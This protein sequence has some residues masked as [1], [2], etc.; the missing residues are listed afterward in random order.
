ML[1]RHSSFVILALA[2]ILVATFTGASILPVDA[3][4][5]SLGYG[6]NGVWPQTA[7][8]NSQRWFR[9]HLNW[10]A[11]KNTEGFAAERIDGL[12]LYGPS[13]SWYPAAPSGATYAWELYSSKGIFDAGTR[14]AGP[15]GVR[16]TFVASPTKVYYIPEP[17]VSYDAGEMAGWE[18]TITT[19][20]GDGNNYLIDDNASDFGGT[21]ITLDTGDPLDDEVC[22]D[23]EITSKPSDTR[24]YYDPIPAV[25]YYPNHTLGGFILRFSLGEARGQEFDIV[26]NSQTGFGYFIDVDEDLPTD[27][28]QTLDADS[29]AS[30]TK[31][32]YSGATFD[33]NELEGQ[34][35]VITSGTATGDER[36][37]SYNGTDGTGDYIE[38]TTNLPAGFAATDT[39]ELKDVM[40]VCDLAQVEN[41]LAANDLPVHFGV[42]RNTPEASTGDNPMRVFTVGPFSNYHDDYLVGWIPTTCPNP[43]FDNFEFWLYYSTFDADQPDN[44]KS[45][46]PIKAKGKHVT[47]PVARRSWEV[48]ELSECGELQAW[49]SGVGTGV[50]PLVTA[51]SAAGGP[52][53]PDNGSGSDEYTF[54]IKYFSG[55]WNWPE[56]RNHWWRHTTPY[57]EFGNEG[58]IGGCGY[59]RFDWFGYNVMKVWG[60]NTAVWNHDDKYGMPD[61][62]PDLFEDRWIYTPHDDPYADM[63]GDVL[64]LVIESYGLDPEAVLI[65]DGD[66]NR[67]HFMVR[68]SGSTWAGG[69]VYRYIVRP[70][71]YLQL[72]HNIFTLQ[73]DTPYIDAWD[74]AYLGLHGEPT[75][76]VYTSMRAGGHTYEFLTCRDWEPPVWGV[77][78]ATEN[79]V[80]NFTA[81]GPCGL[82][83]QGRPGYAIEAAH[84]VN[85]Q[86]DALLYG[87]CDLNVRV[88]TVETWYEDA[89]PAGY[90]YP[91]DSQDPTQYPKV[92]P[93]LT[94]HPYFEDGLLSAAERGFIWP[95]YYLEALGPQAPGS[96]PNPFNHNPTTEPWGPLAGPTYPTDVYG[97]Y[98]PGNPLD[99][100]VKAISP[101][102]FTNEDT[103]W[104]NY[105]NIHKD[106]HPTTPFRGGKWTTDTTFVFRIKYWQSDN[107]TPTSMQ[108]W[109][110]KTGED[111]TPAGD[112]ARKSMGKVYPAD[113]T[114]TDGVVY[115]YEIDAADL[116]GGGGVGDYQYYF[117]SSD[118]TH[119]A[120]YPNRPADGPGYIGVPPGD[121]DYYWFRV[122][123]QPVLLNQSVTPMARPSAEPPQGDFLWDVTY[124]D[125]DGEVRDAGRLGD[126]PFKSILWIDLFGDVEGQAEVV[127]VAGNVIT[128]EVD[129]GSGDPYAASSLVG[130][131]VLMETGSAEGDEFAIT[132]N[133][134]SGPQGTITCTGLSGV[135][136]TDEFDIVDWFAAQMDEANPADTNY[137]NGAEYTT[138]TTKLG[139]QLAPGMHLYYYEFWDNWAYWI[140]WQQYFMTSDPDP[141]DQKVEGEMVRLPETGYYETPYTPPPAPTY[142]ISGTVYDTDGTTALEGATLKCY[143]GAF[144]DPDN[145][146]DEQ[147][148]ASDG[149]YEFEGL[150]DDDYRVIPSYGVWFFDPTEEDVTVSGA[151]ET[152]WDF[153]LVATY[154]ISGTV[155]DIGGSDP[156]EGATLKCYRTP[157]GDPADLVDEQDSGS[158]GTYEF[159]GLINDDYRVIP[160]YGTYT[161]DPTQT[162]VIGLAADEID[163]DFEMQPGDWSIS[164]TILDTGSDPVEGVTVSTN[165]TSDVT[166]SSGDYI[167]GDLPNG[168]YDVDL[169]SP[170]GEYYTY[171]PTP[172]VTVVI[173]DDDEIQ[174]FT[175]T[176]TTFS[177]SGTVLDF[178]DNPISGIDVTDGTN[179]DT[180]VGDGTYTITGVSAGLVTIT[181]EP[182]GGFVFVPQSQDITVPGPGDTDVTGVDF[183]GYAGV[184]HSYSAGLHLTGVPL[185]P[186]PGAGYAEDVFLTD[187]VWWWDPTQSPP[188]IG[189]THPDADSLLQVT[190]GKGFFVNYATATDINVAG[191]AVPTGVPLV[192]PLGDQWNMIANPFTNNLE[193][194]NVR[195][196]DSGTRLP[197]AYV[198]DPI[199]GYLLVTYRTGV[200]VERSYIE[201]WEGAW[202]H[203]KT[204]QTTTTIQM[205]ASP[206]GVEEEGSQELDL[207]ELG[208]VIP[209]A[210]RIG[211]R[212][213]LTGAVGVT[214]GGVEPYSIPNPPRAPESVDLYFV[215][216]GGT[217]L[218]QSITAATGGSAS[219]DFV[220]ATDIP[221]SD[222]EVL[223]PDLS[224]VPNDL[225][226]IITDLDAGQMVYGRTTPSYVFRSGEQ[227][228]VRRFRLEVVP[229][230][231]GGL[232]ITSATAQAA[233]AGAVITYGVSQACA[234]SVEVMNISGQVIK[235]VIAEQAV[236]AG[237]HTQSW[238]LRSNSGTVVPR[239][240]Y[241]VKI[242]AVADNGQCTTAVCPMSIN[243]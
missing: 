23:L 81:A 235:T 197:F 22:P 96:L 189:A 194:T 102:R 45:E 24:V 163:V 111:G 179:T 141:I 100:S 98:N 204:P 130:M 43:E 47:V 87:P 94:A 158:D 147:T 196:T 202:V 15:D 74:V 128:Y 36:E 52:T 184:G 39:F 88:E 34:V 113:I 92:D 238:N 121:N 190:A 173:S 191:T 91:Y 84:V 140:D 217:Q 93:V 198:Y 115:Y 76:N 2:L 66:Y 1:T 123:T 178:E 153:K 3:A 237:M 151:D 40:N 216:E 212:K 68:E 118:G 219:W 166:D 53:D 171:S 95:L 19:G 156:L 168:S 148:S 226:I 79:D 67:P 13:Y 185:Q 28:L 199:D 49:Y 41:V 231:I 172:P 6:G 242:E 10:N 101:F 65:V 207:G 215:G 146:V 11:T 221:D 14:Y 234:V 126:R 106:I 72:F 63:T 125:D 243:R 59:A 71:N 114:Y 7:T 203:A 136:A 195:Y 155:Y 201:P 167:L 210:A 138:D 174:D 58:V 162:D 37:I 232:V 177:V 159:E 229:Q 119:I 183:T 131:Q 220:V 239:G 209:V 175:A 57:E 149:T 160:S 208:W 46:D 186:I 150:P 85:D 77:G 240:M 227:G 89:E 169:T 44:Y 127:S 225:S 25:S 107:L 42:V 224:R 56:L 97:G 161:F 176:E 35:I 218:A 143:D 54:R 133:T 86:W 70:T 48:E 164:G 26:D 193:M 12:R 117:R 27:L 132:A 69:F 187:Q 104:P 32:Y 213:D 62:L 64:E 205:T 154:S 120:I 142:S 29:I 83:L 135:G 38:T 211:D 124:A 180:T 16:L 188:Y 80:G 99:P 50:D 236:T 165:G 192:M 18:L 139:F 170:V 109:I 75:S 230:Q 206:L 55:T 90:G 9:V 8:A 4:S 241:L 152:G 33:E 214:D 103:I 21:Y 144:L 31:F 122:N 137:R 61:L 110:R 134:V 157:Y 20:L 82:A 112:W 116:P 129:G 108:V 105:V 181:A 17:G 200:N 223:L 78:G 73:F 60:N 222:V 145:L 228:A 182:G 30:T 5:L 51:R 233:G